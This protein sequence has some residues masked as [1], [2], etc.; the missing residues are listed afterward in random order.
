MNSVRWGNWLSYLAA[1]SF[2]PRA[3][4]IPRRDFLPL[5]RIEKVQVGLGHG[6]RAVARGYLIDHGDGRFGQNAHRRH[7]QFEFVLAQFVDGQEGLV[8]PCHQDIADAALHEGGGGA[9]RAG[10]E[11]RD[12]LVEPRH[13]ILGLAFVVVGL[14]QGVAPRRQIV[15]ARAAG[16]FGIGRDDGDSGPHQVV[17]VLDVL[18]IAFADQENDGRSVGRAVVREAALPVLGQQSGLVRDGVDVIGQ[19][20]RDHVGLQARR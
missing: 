5:R 15:P 2:R 20:Q 8:L 9:A 14:A 6:G 17:P 1:T 16:G 7:N 13:E 18:G 4:V 10:V 19:R 12:V 3:V 11:H